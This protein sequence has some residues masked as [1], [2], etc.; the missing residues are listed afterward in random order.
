MKQ[1]EFQRT[2]NFAMQDF[3]NHIYLYLLP[4]KNLGIIAYQSK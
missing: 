3:S 2:A 1:T 4:M